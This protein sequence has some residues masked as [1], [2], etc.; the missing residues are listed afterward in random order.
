MER[1]RHFL[2][3]GQDR[4]PDPCQAVQAWCADASL[5]EGRAVNLGIT[6]AER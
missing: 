3:L 5:L 1:E 2:S 4:R 6:R